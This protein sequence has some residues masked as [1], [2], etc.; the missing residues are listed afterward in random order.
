MS[1]EHHIRNEARFENVSNWKMYAFQMEE[2]GREGKECQMVELSNC[3]NLMFGNLWMYRVIRVTT[4]KRFGARLWN[5]ENIQVRNLHNYTQKLWVTEFP[6]W[7]VNKELPLYSWELA[8]LTVTGKET[9]NRIFDDGI[10]KPQKL[11]S[12]F[13][14]AQGIT[15]DS[16]G[17]I[18]F[19]ETRKKR[20]YKWSAET[21]SVSIFADYPFQPFV[22]ATDSKDNLLVV[23]R[24]DPQPGFIVNGQPE[25]VKRLPDDNVA[26]SSWGNSGWAAVC[27]T[28]N[29]ENPDET[30]K[31]LSRIST[32]EI[33]RFQKA[34]YPSSRWHYTFD[35]AAV[36]Y[37][38]SAFVAPDGITY[39]PETYDIGR[40]AQLSEATQGGVIFASDEISKRTVKIEVGDNGK[41]SNLTEILPHG[42]TATAVD[43]DG[44]LYLADGQIFVYDK[45]LKEIN[46]INL[47]ER[48]IS[49]TFGGRDGNSLFVTTV[50]SLFRIKIK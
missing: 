16:K 27:Y 47:S 2:E 11:A 32:S 4:P 22:L 7:D 28:V 19:C 18:Y 8:K 46:R 37:P 17:N 34:F 29:P 38:D 24:Y 45:N 5:C 41:L 30:F 44:N 25:T 36:Y 1:L 26:Y 10:D 20:I 31:P 13:D 42:E 6:F 33:T 23:C 14:F 43:D 49:M 39:I 35:K 9:P 3:K 12:G 15:N 40:C 50:N 21:Q 48:P